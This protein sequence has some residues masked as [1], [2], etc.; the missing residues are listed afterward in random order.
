VAVDKGLNETDKI[1]STGVFKLSNGGSVVINN[2][3][4]PNFSITP[5]VPDE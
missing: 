3:V 1:A 2:S 5:D 4:V